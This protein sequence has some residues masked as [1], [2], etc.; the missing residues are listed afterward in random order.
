MKKVIGKIGGVKI[1]VRESIF[2]G[3]YEW[4]LYELDRIF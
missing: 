2:S 4:N 3:S 1:K